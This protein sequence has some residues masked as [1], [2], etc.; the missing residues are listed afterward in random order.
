M[1]CPQPLGCN[2]GLEA[3]EG[4]EFDAMAP[5]KTLR[6]CGDLETAD[7]RSKR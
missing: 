4:R 5:G 1:C 3:T 6:I 2:L 7:A